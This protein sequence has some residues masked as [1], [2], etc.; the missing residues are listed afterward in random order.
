M[1]A[2]IIALFGFLNIGLL[3]QSINKAK[4]TLTIKIGNIKSAKGNMMILIEDK[5]GKALE[6]KVE[7]LKNTS[8]TITYAVP[9]NGQYA[10][11][12]YQDVNKNNKLDK[13][14]FGAPK[15][16]YG[17]SNNAKATFSAPSL[18]SKLVEVKKDITITINLNH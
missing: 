18:K 11:S 17:F 15:E 8:C 9:S 2:L 14:V 10:V 5:D 1:Y 3:H 6:R 13:N 12:V 16:P 4:P 7:A